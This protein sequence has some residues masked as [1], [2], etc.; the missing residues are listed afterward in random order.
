MLQ[1]FDNHP[2]LDAWGTVEEGVAALA[3]K[4][5]AEAAELARRSALL[6]EKVLG[7]ENYD[8]MM[9]LMNVGDALTSA[10]RG[11][12]AVKTFEDLKGRL[13]R[14]LGPEHPR[15]GMLLNDEE[16]R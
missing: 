9:S 8:T 5:P 11:E 10:G 16:R 15:I 7:K 6:K 12:E 3:E 1:R 13:V 4:R 14:T 2:L